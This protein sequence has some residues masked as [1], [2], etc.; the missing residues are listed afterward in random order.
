MLHIYWIPYIQLVSE[1]AY[2]VT[3]QYPISGKLLEI[4]PDKRISGIKISWISGIRIVSISGIRPDIENDQISGPN[5]VLGPEKFDIYI[6]ILGKEP[7][8]F[9]QSKSFPLPINKVR[10]QSSR[11][12]A[13]RVKY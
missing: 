4:R 3:S 12:V 5:L 2:P 10:L 6:Y 7:P 8:L 9:S 13:S 11:G 1:A